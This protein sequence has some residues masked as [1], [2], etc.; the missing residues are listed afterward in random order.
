MSKC[1]YATFC[2]CLPVPRKR[3]KSTSWRGTGTDPLASFSMWF[4][5]KSWMKPSR[6]RQGHAR[7]KKRMQ[8]KPTQLNILNW[9]F[10]VEIRVNTQRRPAENASCEIGALKN[11]IQQCIQIVKMAWY[12][13]VWMAGSS[14]SV[15]R[16]GNDN[17]ESEWKRCSE[18]LEPALLGMRESLCVEVVGHSHGLITEG[19]Q[20]GDE[21]ER[22]VYGT[23]PL[24]P[25]PLVAC[26]TLASKINK[27]HQTYQTC[28]RS[29]LGP[30]KSIQPASHQIF[31]IPLPHSQHSAL[32]LFGNTM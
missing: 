31:C 17:S 26:Q 22:V 24:D 1:A 23:I 12:E 9:G 15:P 5:K 8:G 18:I 10:W 20:H 7:A 14:F 4:R 6:T 25:P 30:Y 28:V 21:R 16:P 3:C 13:L 11:R 19:Q 27:N 32:D 2:S 29:T